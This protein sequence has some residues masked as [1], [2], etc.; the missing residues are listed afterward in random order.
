MSS[1]PSS[2]PRPSSR[3]SWIPRRAVAQPRDDLRLCRRCARRP[4][5]DAE[6]HAL[7]PALAR[8]FGGSQRP[9][10]SSS[11][12]SSSASSWRPCCAVPSMAGWRG[13]PAAV[14]RIAGRCSS[15]NFASLLLAVLMMLIFDRLVSPQRQPCWS[16]NRNCG[17]PSPPLGRQGVRTIATRTRR[18]ESTG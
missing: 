1:M 5:P 12:F 17:R 9:R 10:S 4:R 7:C 2:L 16:R 18:P 3:L 8:P 13:R 11:C 6:A 15:T 14:D